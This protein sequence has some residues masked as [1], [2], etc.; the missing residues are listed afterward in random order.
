LPKKC[1]GVEFA[2]NIVLAISCKAL[3]SLSTTSFCCGVLGVEKLCV[4][5]KLSNSSQRFSF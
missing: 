4:I 1:L 3:F 2:F 5:P